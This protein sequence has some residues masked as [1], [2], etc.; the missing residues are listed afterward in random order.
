MQPIYYSIII[1]CLSFPLLIGAQPNT[2]D[3]EH[4]FGGAAEDVFYQVIEAS[5]GYIVAVG[6]TQSDTHGKSDGLLVILDHSTGRIMAEKKLGGPKADGLRAVAQLPDGHFMLVGYTESIGMGKSD[7]WLVKVDENGNLKWESTFGGSDEDL[8]SHLIVLPDRTL[9]GL[10]RRDN[11]NNGDIWLAQIKEQTLHHE[12]QLGNGEYDKIRGAVLSLDGQIAIAGNTGSSSKSGKGDAFLIKVEPSGR[13]IWEKSFGEKDWEEATH[14]ITTPDG[15]YALAGLTRSNTAGGMDFWLVKTN[16]AGFQQWQKNYGGKDEDIAQTLGCTPD[17]G[18][19]L[20]G[21]SKSY[22]SGARSFKGYLV[23]T[24]AGGALQWEWPYGGSKDDAVNYLAILHDGRVATAGQTAS[25]SKGAN[26]AWIMCLSDQNQ[27]PFQQLAGIKEDMLKFSSASLNTVD[28][29]LRP[30]ERSFLSFTLANQTQV[31]IRNLQVKVE[32]NSGSSSLRFWPENYLGSLLANGTQTVNI[33]VYGESG[34]STTDN[35]LKITLS[36]GNQELASFE[37]TFASLQPQEAVVEVEKFSFE[38]SRS[39]DEETLKLVLHNPGDFT[40]KSVIVR[41]EPPLGIQAISATE[42]K[43]AQLGS[44]ASQ[45]VEFIYKRTA[46]YRSSQLAIP[47]TVDFNGQKI[48]KTLERGAAMANEV[49]MVLTQPN[50]TK[51]DIQNMVSDKGVFDVQ[52]AVGSNTALQQKNFKVLNNN[53]VI[54]GSKMDEVS[55]SNSSSAAN[56]H[57]YV[58]NNRIHLQPGEN[59]LEIEVETPEGKFRTKTI[60]VRYEPKQPN[61]HILTIG[62]SHQDLQ[63]TS[64]DAADFAAAFENQGGAD[65]LYGKVFIRSLVLP[66]ETEA[67][68]IREAVADLVYQYENSTAAQRI[69]DQD[70]LLVFISSHGKNSRE[71]FQLL[72]SNYDARYERIRSIDFQRDIV[73]ELERIACKK[74]VFIDACHSGAA[75]SKAMT[76]M[77]RADAL[78]RLAAL[79]PGLNT[80]ASCGANE[81][82]YEDAS[83]QNGAFTEAILEAF[84]NVPV[85]GPN[86][87]YQADADANSIITLAELYDYLR[88]RVPDLV[89][90]QKPNA[91]TH[92]VPFMPG[93]ETAARQMPVFVLD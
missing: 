59:R 82:S 53:M 71:G 16:S 11:A 50:E 1:L 60:L 76:D 19:L 32:Q 31:N 13:L 12:Q 62:P 86:G 39:S 8:F 2:P 9:V 29:K 85:E 45:S 38:D 68:D 48:R 15:G 21:Y 84:S 90:L 42:V 67:D 74:A 70:V 55:L 18:Y 80:M 83:W 65:K 36:S 34:L 92:Q 77:E 4:R 33:P 75:D 69:L 7:A 14:L 81:M 64:K 25:D 10:G 3:W 24:D 26:D 89:K 61:L 28:G 72:P 57:A 63:Y 17:G 47:C 30:G 54:D 43:L 93:N 20:A 88:Q 91:P 27:S 52:V 23:K 51:A 5:N 66:E 37:S 79:H 58:Y 49:F 46:T 22:H 6:E 41:F 35:Q 78:N 87:S 44:H 56:K 40:A 73:Q